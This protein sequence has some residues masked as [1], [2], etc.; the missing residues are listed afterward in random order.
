MKL[1]FTTVTQ[2]RQDELQEATVALFQSLAGDIGG[3]SMETIN[4]ALG[5]FCNT[6]EELAM[7]SIIAGITLNKFGIV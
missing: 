5:E 1:D 4:V 3:Q 6:S 2:E 7:C